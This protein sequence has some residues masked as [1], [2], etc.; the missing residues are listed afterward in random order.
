MLFY[1]VFGVIVGGR[2]GYILFYKPLHYLANP[3]EIF[4]VWSGA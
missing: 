1:G 2:L 4:A 3:L